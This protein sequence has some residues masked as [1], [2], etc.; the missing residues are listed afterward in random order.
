[1]TVASLH[2]EMWGDSSFI[3]AQGLKQKI[4]RASSDQTQHHPDMLPWAAWKT[5]EFRHVL[6]SPDFLSYSDGKLRRVGWEYGSMGRV[7]S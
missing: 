2:R 7:L 4:Q 6:A 5:S 3:Q 1:M